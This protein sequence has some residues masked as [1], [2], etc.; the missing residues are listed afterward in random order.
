MLEQIQAVTA[1]WSI[2]IYIRKV[3]PLTGSKV[4][5]R[6]VMKAGEDGCTQ[7]S[8][9]REEIQRAYLNGGLSHMLA[10]RVTRMPI[11]QPINAQVSIQDGK[12]RKE[13]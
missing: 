6:A 2:F 8:S 12:L 5:V 7:A 13:K 11:D 3:L 9:N 1:A 10:L 4:V